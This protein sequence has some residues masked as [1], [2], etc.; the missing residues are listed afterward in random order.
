[1]KNIP[2]SNNH[3]YHLIFIATKKGEEEASCGGAAAYRGDNEAVPT[4]SL[5]WILLYLYWRY[6]RRMVAPA[7]REGERGGRLLGGERT[8]TSSGESICHHLHRALG[9]GGVK[10]EGQYLATRK[11]SSAMSPVPAPSPPPQPA[12]DGAEPE[13]KRTSGPASGCR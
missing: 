1:M 4:K 12:D 6:I 11:L 10:E 8:S 2:N 3:L 7:S 9:A 13:A 5:V